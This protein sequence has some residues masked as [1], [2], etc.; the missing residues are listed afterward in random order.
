[1]S[2]DAD[3][4]PAAY[5]D[6]QAFVVEYGRDLLDVLDPRPGERILDLGCGTGHLT[7]E[8]DAAV[9]EAGAAIGID[10]SP[11]MVAEARETYPDREFARVDATAFEPTGPFDAV[12]SNAALH[13]IDD[14]D[15]ALAAVADALRPGGRFVAELG[16]TGNVAAIVD[17]VRAEGRACGVQ[18]EAPW[19]F[20]SLGDYATRLESHG[21]EVRLAR[22]FERETTLDGP[23]GLESWL[24]QFGDDLLAAFDDPADAV[25]AVE[26]RLRSTH[27]DSGAEEWTVTYR[28]LQFRAILPAESPYSS[29]Q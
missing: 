22:V 17:A 13:W 15:A 9:G 14:Q 26:D 3:F 7:A 8:I 1:M 18:V 27:Y 23:D 24:D 4:D 28:R 11:A 19:H 2:D 21:F 29:S 10:A 6:R 16:T 5:D 12:F 20:P 25:A